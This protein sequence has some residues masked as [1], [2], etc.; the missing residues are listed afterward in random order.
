MKLK[1]KRRSLIKS[2][3]A[4]KPLP[5]YSQFVDIMNAN[6][7]KLSKKVLDHFPNKLHKLFICCFASDLTM[8]K[9]P[10]YNWIVQRSAEELEAF[11]SETSENDRKFAEG[12]A[13]TLLN[14]GFANNVK[15]TVEQIAQAVF[16]S[17]ATVC[18]RM[19]Y[20]RNAVR[21]YIIHGNTKA[22][23]PAVCSI[24]PSAPMSYADFTIL[25]AS[26]ST[27][28]NSH[29]LKK[30][31]HEGLR[32]LLVLIHTKS[33]E[34]TEEVYEAFK[35]DNAPINSILKL[36]GED[37]CVRDCFVCCVGLNG[38]DVHTYANAGKH[39]GLSTGATLRKFN[40]ALLRLKCTSYAYV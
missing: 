38:Y 35:Q 25:A 6:N 36:F 23:V 15:M 26:A 14:L 33:L 8:L 20:F 30:C 40:Q 37:E 17:Q 7:S 27:K 22:K 5:D 4:T 32:L 10:V 31:P 12:A 13:W 3:P 1:M 24:E 16:I 18:R 19:R 29:L 2:S 39:I 21:R 11:L 9:E 28:I 34:L